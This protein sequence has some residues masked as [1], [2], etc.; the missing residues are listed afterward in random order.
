MRHF[1]IMK[2]LV[3]RVLITSG[4]RNPGAKNRHDWA[5][6][7]YHQMK[8]EFQISFLK[9]H[10]LLPENTLLD[11]GCGTLR[12]G[13]PIIDYL[14]PG[15]YC[16]VDVRPRVLV[17]AR[18]ELANNCLVQKGPEILLLKEAH[19]HLTMTF[20][21]IWAFQVFQH[22]SLAKL[23]EALEFAAK[24][25]NPDGILYGTA[26]IGAYQD[27]E[28]QGFPVLTRPFVFYRNEA[29]KYGLQVS[30]LGT[31][32][33]LGYGRQHGKP[34]EV[35]MLKFRLVSVDADNEVEFLPDGMLNNVDLRYESPEIEGR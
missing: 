21:V 11:F 1:Q 31:L 29:K 24:H 26:P 34:S 16:G 33:S 10:G 5:G 7:G 2:Q 6:P 30:S 12:G 8:K 22:L 32:D 17:E 35:V 15:N 25:L 9:S 13:I 27:G 4:V 23:E 18:K 3:N 20:D 14:R 19:K 28:W